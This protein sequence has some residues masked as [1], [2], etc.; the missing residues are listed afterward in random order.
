MGRLVT[1]SDRRNAV[2]EAGVALPVESFYRSD[3]LI[4]YIEEAR[5]T[6]VL[7]WAKPLG[8]KGQPY[9]CARSLSQ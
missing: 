5:T 8:K 9:V 6:Q 4:L 2:P 7:Y 3:R 1:A